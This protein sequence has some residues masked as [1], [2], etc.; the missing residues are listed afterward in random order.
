MG[1]CVVP[2]EAVVMIRFGN[3]SFD[4]KVIK[5]KNGVAKVKLVVKNLG[6]TWT[7]GWDVGLD[8]GYEIGRTR[9]LDLESGDEGTILSGAGS[10]A[11]IR[12]GGRKTVKFELKVGEDDI[13]EADI[14]GALFP[15]GESQQDPGDEVRETPTVVEPPP[16]DEPSEDEPSEDES[17]QDNDGN[18]VPANPTVDHGAGQGA[19]EAT[20]DGTDEGSDGDGS[21]QDEPPPA[22]GHPQGGAPA[23]AGFPAGI[24]A[25]TIVKSAWGTGCVMEIRIC[26]TGD[27]P[28][29]GWQLAFT[30]AGPIVEAWRADLVQA[31]DGTWKA[32]NESWNAELAPGEAVSFGFKIEVDPS[33][34]GTLNENIQFIE[35][36]VENG[37]L[38]ANLPEPAP[39]AEEPAEDPADPPADPDGG[40]VEPE[41]QPEPA[42]DPAP[43]P[44]P[45]PSSEP[46]PDPDPA[47]VIHVSSDITT[48]A[49]QNLVDTA[50]AGSVLQLEAGTFYFTDTLMIT[51]DDITLKGAGMGETILMGVDSGTANG[52]L[53]YVSG[54]GKNTIATI[55]EDMNK[56]ENTLKLYQGHPISV[57]D[58]LFIQQESDAEFLD[59]IGSVDWRH[60]HSIRNTVAEVVA[61]NGDEITLRDPVG[62]DYDMN[63]AKV[64][65]VDLVENVRL[66]DFT[67]T[68]DLGEPDMSSSSN[69]LDDRYYRS[70]AITLRGTFEAELAN[71]EALNSAS[72]AFH[73]RRAL[74][75]EADNLIANGAHNKGGG[76]NGYAF[77][78]EDV[79][80]SDFSNLRDMD[81]RHGFTMGSWFSSGDNDVH[82][83]FTNRDVNFH[84]G[85]DYNNTVIVDESIADPANTG[86]V[87]RPA[88]IK[89][90]EGHWGAPTDPTTNSI[91]FTKVITDPIKRT[92]DEVHATDEGAYMATYSGHDSLHGGAGD[93]TLYGGRHNDQLWGNQGND[94]FV[95][96]AE[97]GTWGEWTDVIHDFTVGEDRLELRDG[98]T[99]ETLSAADLGYG[100]G[101]QDTTVR[102]SDGSKIVLVDAVINNEDDLFQ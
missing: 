4:V 44:E 42:I 38:I 98:L 68:Y 79:Y 34:A 69:V 47:N 67:V 95:F 9:K 5:V 45:E 20:G 32:S 90:P 10:R 33:L 37:E 61:V 97:S 35:H 28:I 12:P 75:L 13:S 99:V 86:E 70:E 24:E 15:V 54:E 59:S 16:E 56:G 49:L 101:Q 93:D 36:V 74:D 64:S 80:S 66:S 27:H 25:E 17:V 22:D 65:L 52:R 51:R 2:T 78:L 26:N 43:D 14:L 102:L 57:G 81:M 71:I 91:K 73:F 60:N 3:L 87:H 40:S 55:Q 72:T 19:G 23:Q 53:I 7:D 48:E 30:Q 100:G 88:S 92:H 63:K 46:Q 8:T 11:D 85:R 58:K 94:T 1:A 39:T 76:G 82:I 96:D 18:E 84:G 50:P 89:G 41:P 62:F 31:D 29:N 83:A 21:E 77:E 6:D